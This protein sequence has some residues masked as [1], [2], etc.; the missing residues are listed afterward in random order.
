V[1]RTN[2]CADVWGNMSKPKIVKKVS[3]GERLF[4]PIFAAKSVS[5]V[6]LKRTEDKLKLRGNNE[7]LLRF[8]FVMCITMVMSA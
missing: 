1:K 8:V 7:D 5:Q 4:V 2:I 6:T 3:I